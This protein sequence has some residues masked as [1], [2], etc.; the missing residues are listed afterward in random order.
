MHRVRQVSLSVAPQY[1]QGHTV[2]SQP[3]S[4]PQ[5]HVNAHVSHAWHFITAKGSC[6]RRPTVRRRCRRRQPLQHLNP[7][8]P[9]PSQKGQGFIVIVQGGI[10]RLTSV[11][12]P[13]A[14]RSWDGPCMPPGMVQ[15]DRDRNT[16]TNM[17]KVGGGRGARAYQAPHAM[18][19]KSKKHSAPSPPSPTGPSQ[20]S[21]SA[22]SFSRNRCKVS[23]CNRRKIV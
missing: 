11:V 15:S 1:A 16:V 4:S 12:A 22:R 17:Q 23:S 19:S 18:G 10:A 20:P 21:H 13:L 14:C 2:P 8:H 3:P 7:Q 5:N 9:L 6:V